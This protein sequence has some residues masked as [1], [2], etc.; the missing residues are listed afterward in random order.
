[1]AGSSM[2]MQEYEA[3]GQP[4]MPVRKEGET[5]VGSRV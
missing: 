1:M 3:T 2:T 5:G 4:G